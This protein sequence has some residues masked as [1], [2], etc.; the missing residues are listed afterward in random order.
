M[1]PTTSPYSSIGSERGRRK[2]APVVLAA[3]LLCAVCLSGCLSRR[4]VPTQVDSE[5]AAA[6]N[7]A[8]EQPAGALEAEFRGA[9]ITW[10]DE[11]GRRVMEAQFEEALASQTG[12]EAVVELRSVKARLYKGGKLA[13]SLVAPRVVADS[14]TKEIR[15]SGGVEIVSAE[16]D[17][18][19]RA[20]R[21]VWK[22][23]EDKLIGT[24]A[25]RMVKENVSF[26][27]RSFESDTALKKAK[28][29]DGKAAL[30]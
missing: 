6:P 17:A 4:A 7:A 29:G 21:V 13:S 23:R 11:K 27:A 24:G 9:Q 1:R 16:N 3:A 15:A 26:T 8:V 18:S 19:G 25:V 12:D 20:E 5:K 2:L 28:F 30:R 10:D 14:R 22:S